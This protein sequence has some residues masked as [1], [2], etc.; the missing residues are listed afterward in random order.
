MSSLA[1]NW[2]WE[3]NVLRSCSRLAFMCEFKLAR[4]S[5]VNDSVVIAHAE[6]VDTRYS[7]PYC[8]SVTSILMLT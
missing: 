6:A 3:V 7:F 4:F 8:G 1:A 5:S 2:C